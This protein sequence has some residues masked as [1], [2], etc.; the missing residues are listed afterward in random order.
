MVGTPA[1]LQSW[2][3]PRIQGDSQQR[4]EDRARVLCDVLWRGQGGEE[5][6]LKGNKIKELSAYWSQAVKGR[7]SLCEASS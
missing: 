4:V 7:E 6:L 2:V 5:F 3:W 1:H